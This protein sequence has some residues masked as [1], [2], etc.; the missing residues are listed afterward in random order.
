MNWKPWA[1]QLK[2]ERQGIS[3][4]CVSYASCNAYEIIM[5]QMGIGINLSDRYLAVISETLRTGQTIPHVLSKFR[6]H[7]VV[8][9]VEC[10]FP[11][12]MS[13]FANYQWMWNLIFNISSVNPAATRHKIQYFHSFDTNITSLQQGLEEGPLIL[14]IPSP[15][16]S[17]TS[18]TVVGLNT[19]GTT[20][21]VYDS[22]FQFFWF[23]PI[24][25]IKEAYAIYI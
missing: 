7:G 8:E 22:V 13:L 15:F 19:I 17:S 24:T 21:E 12:W 3:P 23:T 20:M 1:L 16:N 18:H 4:F 25:S 2:E 14:L 11:W 9:E 10:Q 6:D 5:R